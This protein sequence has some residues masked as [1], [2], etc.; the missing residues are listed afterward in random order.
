[1]FGTPDFEFFSPVLK[2]LVCLPRVLCIR[3]CM[4]FYLSIIIILLVIIWVEV[5]QMVGL[6][7]WIVPLSHPAVLK[8]LR[9]KKSK[10]NNDYLFG[11]LVLRAFFNE[12][13]ADTSMWIILLSDLMWAHFPSPGWCSDG[14]LG[15]FLALKL[16]LKRLLRSFWYQCYT[17]NIHYVPLDY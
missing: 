11:W 6:F 14:I 4:R 16:P 2:A 8:M 17:A 9:R 1:M 10:K 13:Y 15:N 7:Q 5:P 3:K 12:T